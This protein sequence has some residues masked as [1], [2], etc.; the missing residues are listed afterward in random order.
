MRVSKT[1]FVGGM[2]AMLAGCSSQGGGVSSASPEG[3]SASTAS[4]A[5]KN[6]EPSTKL[7]LKQIKEAFD[8]IDDL[9]NHD[10]WDKKKAAFIAALG[11]PAKTN[12]DYLTW[13]G[14]E[15]GKR[16]I[17]LTAGP[18]QTGWK[19]ADTAACFGGPDPDPGPTAKPASAGG[20]AAAPAADASASASA[21]ESG[22]DVYAGDYVT[23]WG[24]CTL[25]VDGDKVKGVCPG[26]G[27]S[28]SCKPDKDSLMCSWSESSGSGGARLRRDAATGRLN[29]TWGSGGS[30][31][32]GGS[33]TFTPNK[34]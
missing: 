34:K 4:A 2:V 25:K 7:T 19:D 30:M 11:E 23:E 32:S 5:A 22:L 26:R 6:T 3:S 14:L 15:N 1:V 12:G 8:K 29:G 18:N 17:K 28:L 27:T 24:G 33:W 20:S 10:P 13:Y 9:S 21:G 16:C 31:S